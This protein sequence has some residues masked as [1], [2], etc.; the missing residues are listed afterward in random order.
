MD[1]LPRRAA[2]IFSMTRTSLLRKAERVGLSVFMIS[3]HWW[4]WW[5]IKYDQ[6]FFQKSTEFRRWRMGGSS[7][8][9]A[10]SSLYI[11]INDLLWRDHDQLQLG[12]LVPGRVLSAI[13]D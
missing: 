5:S 2:S 6:S 12:P 8:K 11:L 13:A 7:S 3:D 4:F 10:F 9:L 1:G